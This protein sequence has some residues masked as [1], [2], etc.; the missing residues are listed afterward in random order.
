MA[1]NLKLCSTCD[2][3][4]LT[5]PS[6]TWCSECNQALCDDCKD[7]HSVFRATQN[8]ETV[9]IGCYLSL[10]D[11]VN[12]YS[13]HCSIHNDRYQLY[14]QTHDT[15]FCL[16]C[17]EEHSGCKDIIPLSKKTKDI[18]TS[19]TFKDADQSLKDI[20]ENIS[21]ME[22]VVTNNLEVLQKER[23]AVLDN[24]GRIR[25]EI[26]N[27]LDKLETSFLNEVSKITELSANNM[28]VTLKLLN[29]KKSKGLEYQKQQLEDI[30]N[31]ASELQT[32]LGLR[33]ISPEMSKM[34]I[35]LRSMIENGSLDK[36][37]LICSINKTLNDITRNI[38][39]FGTI[40]SK[41]VS[42]SMKLIRK[43]DTQAQI[44]GL[45]PKSIHD[46]KTKLLQRIDIESKNIMGCD[47]LADGRMVFSSYNTFRNVIV[48]TDSDGKQPSEIPVSLS[49]PFDVTCI[50]NN[51]VA[52]TSGI[53]NQGIQLIDIESKT[54]T[55]KISTEY[56]C[57][58][59]TYSNGL[60]FYCVMGKGI[61][62]FT[63]KDSNVKRIVECYLSEWPYVSSFRDKLYYAQ[64]DKN[65]VI[66]CNIDGK[67][68]W[69]FKNESILVYPGGL[70]VDN[71]GYIYIVSY[72]HNSVILRMV[73]S[74]EHFYQDIVRFKG[75]RQLSLIRRDIIC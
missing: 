24:I 35:S 63:I 32:Y 52:V 60:L 34:E 38:K 16:F 59:I 42:A 33:Q 62:R 29:D 41:K 55:Q 46:I 12:V 43:K 66:C 71:D 22:T 47:I 27:H 70:S 7:Y 54:V 2:V 23:G 74:L 28:Q 49:Q 6:T 13:S 4:H 19:D 25:Q 26:N 51:T 45:S 1:N 39:T 56:L 53:S 72:Q 65:T 20:D 3:R 69:T 61:Y 68:N 58:G 30:K 15:P 18:K 9:E 36:V 73:N 67:F 64:R 5:K 8:H 21:K 44:I 10:S 37:S 57:H 31:H 75:P 40:R 17:V 14:C 11:S 50:D 48:I